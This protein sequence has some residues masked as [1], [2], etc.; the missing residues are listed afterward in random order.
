MEPNAAT[1]R[2]RSLW[3]ANELRD[4]AKRRGLNTLHYIGGIGHTT[5]IAYFLQNPNF[6]FE[7]LEEYRTRR[8]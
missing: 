7:R 3:T 4:Y 5:E 6:S 2:E 8:R 1:G